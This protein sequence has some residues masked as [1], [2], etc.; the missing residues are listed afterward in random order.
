MGRGE[1]G[2]GRGERREG[3][4]R[5]R[6]D[7]NFSIQVPVDPVVMLYAASL[8]PLSFLKQNEVITLANDHITGTTPSL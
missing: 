5:F 4:G 6:V 7:C 3:R 2:E 1:R 8:F